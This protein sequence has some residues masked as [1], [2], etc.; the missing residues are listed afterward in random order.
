MIK[1]I[2]KH[3]K[4]Y[5]ENKIAAE[6]NIRDLYTYQKADKPYASEE[7]IYQEIIKIAKVNEKNH[8]F[9]GTK[10]F[11]I[12]FIIIIYGYMF[13]TTLLNSNDP[14]S[15][16]SSVNSSLNDMQSLDG[17]IWGITIG[18]LL[19]ALT[20]IFSCGLIISLIWLVIYFYDLKERK[21]ANI[22]FIMI[23]LLEERLKELQN[24][25]S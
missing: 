18:F 16:I 13:N 6:K 3:L 10:Y 25:K 21:P 1:N 17:P 7:E 5:K 20:F 22:T 15:L 23:E 2:D 4:K 9:N 14:E 12:S 8:N 19:I 24:N 11:F